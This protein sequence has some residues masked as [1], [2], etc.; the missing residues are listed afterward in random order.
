MLCLP[1]IA[2]V[3]G[4]YPAGKPDITILKDKLVPTIEQ[5]Q[6]LRN[7][8]LRIIADDGYF[9]G[10]LAHALAWRNEL[11]P[12]DLAYYKGRALSRHEYVNSLTK[13]FKCLENTFRHDHLDPRAPPVAPNDYAAKHK[14]H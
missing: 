11:D 10:D 1:K 9:I 14:T 5:K 13:N 12:K 7:N 8:N 3:N 6:A 4:P 2:W